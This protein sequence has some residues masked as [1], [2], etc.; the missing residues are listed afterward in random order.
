MKQLIIS[1]LIF[2][3]LSVKS[4]IIS[5]DTSVNYF[6]WIAGEIETKLDTTQII[7]GIIRE[8]VT[9]FEHY[10]VDAS[11]YPVGDSILILRL[12]T[13][14]GYKVGFKYFDWEWKPVKLERIVFVKPK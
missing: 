4:Q 12:S 7:L 11:Y 5:Q 3:S 1:I 2:S 9:T 10:Y 14:L 6:K 8:E 13:E